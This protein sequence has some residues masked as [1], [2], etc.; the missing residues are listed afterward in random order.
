MPITKESELTGMKRVSE[1]VAFTLKQMRNFAQPGIT[2]KELDNNSGQILSD[3][4]ARSALSIVF[5]FS[6]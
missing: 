2:I 4:G 6:H 1:A 3:M 5:V